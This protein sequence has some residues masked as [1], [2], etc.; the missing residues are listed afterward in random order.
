MKLGKQK[1]DLVRFWSQ[2]YR[3]SQ[4]HRPLQILGS[5]PFS[6]FFSPSIKCILKT[7]TDC[8]SSLDLNCSLLHLSPNSTLKIQQFGFSWKPSC[9]HLA[10]NLDCHDWEYFLKYWVPCS[11]DIISLRSNLCSKHLALFKI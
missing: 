6:T 7:S 1:Y 11:L 9:V 10:R 2:L 5:S 4:K 3:S 8:L